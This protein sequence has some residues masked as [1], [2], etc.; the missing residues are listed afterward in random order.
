MT[1]STESATKEI[2]KRD[3]VSREGVSAVYRLIRD[4]DRFTVSVECGGQS[5][6]VS[7]FPGGEDDARR[8][9]A[10]A[11]KEFVLP[12]TLAD[13]WRDLHVEG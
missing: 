9:Y 6:E 7:A 12:G 4:G 3:E 1:A 8:L 10:I 5:E 11:V 2:V 13:V